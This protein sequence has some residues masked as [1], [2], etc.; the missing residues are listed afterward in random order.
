MPPKSCLDD[1]IKEEAER[2]FRHLLVDFAM[3]NI[4][5][6]GFSQTYGFQCPQWAPLS[7]ALKS[8]MTMIYP[9]ADRAHFLTILAPRQA[10]LWHTR[11]GGRTWRI[12]SKA[13]IPCPCGGRPTRARSAICSA[14]PPM[15]P[16]CRPVT[17]DACAAAALSTLDETVQKLK[18]ASIAELFSK[19]TKFYK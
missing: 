19:S 2:A 13:N 16:F 10:K 3:Q 7:L 9:C 17:A 12:S 15:C 18:D 11:S 14:I 1:A 5:E 8:P 4:P 6:F